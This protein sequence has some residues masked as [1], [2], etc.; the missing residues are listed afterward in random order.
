MMNGENES[1]AEKKLAQA[2]KMLEEY[3]LRKG[4]LPIRVNNEAENYLNMDANQLR[5]LN[6]DECGEAATILSL[7]AVHLQKVFND[8][9]ARVNWANAQISKAIYKEVQQ[10]SG[11][12]AEERKLKVVYSN[13]YTRKLAEIRTIAQAVVD[14][15][16][17]MTA[18]IEFV[19]R[20][21]L[22]LQQS[23][24]KNYV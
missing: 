6:A 10:Q 20:T 1:F 24:R 23:R 8:Q 21:L 3:E 18:R 17:Y 2:E 13:E 16:S 11:Y 14:R 9:L 22:S 7:Y 19:A 5:K 12:S 15:L 4:V